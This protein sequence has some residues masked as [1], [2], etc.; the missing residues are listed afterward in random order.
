MLE[1]I[2]FKLKLIDGERERVRGRDNERERER[3]QAS[4]REA[5]I[6]RNREESGRRI[7]VDKKMKEDEKCRAIKIYTLFI[8]QN[9]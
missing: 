9:F 8:T 1:Y 3:D 4:E 5:N 7:A 2:F 6:G